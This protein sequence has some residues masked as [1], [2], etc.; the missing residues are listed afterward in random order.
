MLNKKTQHHKITIHRHMRNQKSLTRKKWKVITIR[1]CDALWR[2]MPVNLDLNFWFF[3]LL[4]IS[5]FWKTYK[6]EHKKLL[7]LRTFPIY[8]F[9]HTTLLYRSNK[10]PMKFC[11]I[12]LKGIVKVVTI[13]LKGVAMHELHSIII[14]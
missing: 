14:V 9:K 2:I 1:N 4:N 3:F 5:T 12:T 8:F 6:T 13:A 11:F 10:Y 7:C